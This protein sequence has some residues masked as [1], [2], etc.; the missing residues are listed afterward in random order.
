MIR[1][2]HMVTAK[3]LKGGE[4]VM[5]YLTKARHSPKDPNYS[6][7][8]NLEFVVDYEEDSVMRTTFINPDTIEPVAVKPI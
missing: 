1:E 7:P 4:T 8:Y 5:G 6:P 2:R 3:R